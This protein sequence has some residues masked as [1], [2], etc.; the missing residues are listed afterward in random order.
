MP[1]RLTPIEV[2]LDADTV[3]FQLCMGPPAQLVEQ[4]G[5]VGQAFGELR[6]NGTS[7][8]NL[9]LLDGFDAVAPERLANQSQV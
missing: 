3:E 2:E 5:D 4:T 9:Q 7:D 6:S 1:L 8:R